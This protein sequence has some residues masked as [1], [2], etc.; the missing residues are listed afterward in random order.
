M[1]LIILYSFIIV[2]GVLFIIGWRAGGFQIG[3]AGIFIAVVLAVLREYN[4]LK[5]WQGLGIVVLCIAL[6]LVAYRMNTR[7]PQITER[8]KHIF[9]LGGHLGTCLQIGVYN[10]PPGLMGSTCSMPAVEAILE[11]LKYPKGRR[12][13]LI[14]GLLNV[15]QALKG[16]DVMKNP[17]NETFLKSASL[18]GEYGRVR[19]PLKDFLKTKYGKKE[20]LVFKMGEDI[21]RLRLVLVMNA[22]KAE[23]ERQGKLPPGSQ[24]PEYVILPE[25]MTILNGFKQLSAYGK[26][27]FPDEL[28]EPI[29]VIATSNI[30]YPDGRKKM[31]DA[32]VKIGYLFD[33]PIP[34]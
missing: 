15:T 8:D 28:N 2:C 1:K 11:S 5:T 27:Y 14:S 13:N 4:I 6:I 12:D 17:T 3:L 18:M 32:I 9:L 24:L 19:E 23:W 30:V 33:Q 25:T 7:K 21:P 22:D 16:L 29:H 31:L 10:P 34:K 20:Y 26:N